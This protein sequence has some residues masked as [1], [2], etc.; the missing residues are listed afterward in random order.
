M[1]EPKVAQKAFDGLKPGT[2]ERK[3]D[4]VVF[5]NGR[6]Y[7]L[8]LVS[9]QQKYVTE[10]DDAGNPTIKIVSSDPEATAFVEAFIELSGENMDVKEDEQGTIPVVAAVIMRSDDHLVAL[11]KLVRH[12]LLTNYDFT[13][14]HLTDIVAVDPISLVRLYQNILAHILRI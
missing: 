11:M 13:N 10:F 5:P 9:R 3:S 1:N 2:D 6:Q 4:W 7:L 12:L 14:A 8:P